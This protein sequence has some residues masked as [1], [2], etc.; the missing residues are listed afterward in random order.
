MAEVIADSVSLS[1]NLISYNQGQA[2]SRFNGEEART[3]TDTV[4]FSF[5]IGTTPIESSS[6]SVFTALRYLVLYTINELDLTVSRMVR[7]YV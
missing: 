4:S 7:T 6:L 2:W 3:L 5:T 1:P